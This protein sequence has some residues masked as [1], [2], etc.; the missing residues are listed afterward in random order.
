M[1]YK[2]TIQISTEAENKK[3]AM[4]IVGEYLSGNIA[5][6][7]EMRY[8]TRPANSYSKAAIGALVVVTLVAGGLFSTMLVRHP[9]QLSSCASGFNAVQPPLKTF[10]AAKKKNSNFKTE[11]E[12]RQITEALNR[13]K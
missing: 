5:S 8:F 4:E 1:K 7:I 12:K 3:E 6:G 9:Q 10:D 2:T 11:W 13:I